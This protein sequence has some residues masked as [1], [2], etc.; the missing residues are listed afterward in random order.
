MLVRLNHRQVP[1]RRIL[2]ASVA[3]ML[4]IGGC[5]QSASAAA[6]CPPGEVWGDVGCRPKAQP[7]LAARA[8]KRI[9]NRFHKAKAK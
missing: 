1:M 8:A 4:T 3:V 9:R 2:F 5:G 7:S 6:R